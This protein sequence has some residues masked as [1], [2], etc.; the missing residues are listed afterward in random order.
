MKIG[1]WIKGGDHGKNEAG[2]NGCYKG[3][4]PPTGMHH[5]H[6]MVYTLNTTLDIGENTGKAGLGKS[7]P[8]HILSQGELISLYKK[9]KS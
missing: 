1:L 9:T 5:Y 3:M 6:L 8:G 7:M 2:Q 4:C